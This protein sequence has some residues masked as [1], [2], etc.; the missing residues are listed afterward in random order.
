MFIFVQS[1]SVIMFFSSSQTET[2]G[3]SLF[4]GTLSVCCTLRCW[5]SCYNQTRERNWIRWE[6]NLQVKRVWNII[7]LPELL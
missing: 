3:G 2:R 7:L 1:C 5:T 4:A 6:A